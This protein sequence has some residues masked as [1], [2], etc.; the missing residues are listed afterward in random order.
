MTCI[1]YADCYLFVR[2]LIVKAFAKIYVT[3][4][5]MFVIELVMRKTMILSRAM[6]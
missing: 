1:C 5:V 2:L 3:I 4:A 6:K